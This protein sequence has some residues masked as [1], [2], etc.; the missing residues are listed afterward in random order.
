MVLLKN[1]QVLEK[2]LMQYFQFTSFR[3]GQKEIIQ[4]VL[5]GHDVFGI[6]P[7]GSGKSLC[8]QLPAMILS[9]LTIVV[10]PLIALMVDQVRHLKMKGFKR[11]ATLNSFLP[12][13]VRKR[14]LYHLSYYKLLYISPELLQKKE[15]IDQLKKIPI[16]LFVID[17]AHCISQWGYE[18]RPDY[19][20][21]YSV[22]KRLG[23]PP[24][25]ALSATASKE[26]QADIMHHLKRKNMKK[27]IYPMDRENIVFTVQ[28]VEK[29]Q[30]KLSIIQS[31]L[32]KWQAPTLIYFSSRKDT[33]RVAR[34]LNDQ[35]PDLK[36][37][38]YHG[39]LDPVDRLVIQQ[40]FMNDQID[41]ICA[42]SAFGMGIDKDNIRLIIHYHFPYEIESFIQESGRAG[43]DGKESVSLVLY[44]PYDQ[45]L[46]E[47]FIAKELPTETQIKQVFDMIFKGRL[48]PHQLPREI[49]DWAM[50]MDLNETQWRFLH[51]QFEQRSLTW[52]KH[53]NF[54]DEQLKTFYQQT[55]N[56]RKE[57]VQLKHKKLMEMIEW[58]NK[59]ECLRKHLYK[60]FQTTYKKPLNFCCSNCD[61]QLESWKPEQTQK[62]SERELSWERKLKK[63]FY[64][65]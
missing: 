8:Y 61:L 29:D 12:Y 6:L 43:R 48:Q 24:L 41:C 2:H 45:A 32:K 38:Y 22:I 20:R 27:H 55:L 7:T 59:E 13:E 34:I 25:L 53:V 5:K 42:T 9:G 3:E 16:R 28:R 31:L 33:E 11:V 47:S 14:I 63:I 60:K 54:D 51:Y 10:S 57:R 30:E 50:N 56:H 37:A 26:V 4:D 23:N 58:L 19:L 18:F 40:Q 52:Q 17:E 35:L 65:V 15:M 39:N 44:A 64:G 21:L 1:D 46:P 36:I 62:E 49:P